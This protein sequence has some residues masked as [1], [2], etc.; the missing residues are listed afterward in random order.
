MC[1]RQAGAEVVRR[2]GLAD[3]ADVVALALDRHQRGA[4]DRRACRAG[5]RD[6][7]SSFLARGVVLEHRLDRLE[8]ELGREVEHG[9][10][11]VVERLD[12]VGLVGLAVGQVP[13][14]VGMALACGASAFIA[15]EGGEL[16]EARID[17]PPR[18][19]MAAGA[20]WRSGS[21]R[22]SRS[23][24]TVAS[25]FTLVGLMLAVDRAGHQG[26][27]ARA[28]PRSSVSAMTAAAASA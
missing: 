10:V 4:A 19:R 27:A 15:H 21:S 6:R 3:G 20:R 18:A 24:S 17:P 8:V 9:E 5:G 23:A 12:R 16:H 26:H 2:H 1:G 7:S 11:L 13:E 22:T 14:Q 25:S 28:W